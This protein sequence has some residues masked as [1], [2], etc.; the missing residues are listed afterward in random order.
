L[1]TERG[2]RDSLRRGEVG[3]NDIAP[4][5]VN[6]IVADRDEGIHGTGPYPALKDRAELITPLRGEL[7][8]IASYHSVGKKAEEMSSSMQ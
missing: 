1:A 6:S 5:F 8:L 4:K 7:Q 2:V 3:Q